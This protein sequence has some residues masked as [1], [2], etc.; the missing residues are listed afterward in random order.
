MTKYKKRKEAQRIKCEVCSKSFLVYR[1]QH[2]F[3][4]NKCRQVHFLQ[5]KAD[6]LAR[7]RQELKEARASHYS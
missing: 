6:E 3:C 4:S 1:P 5:G 2:K 7:L